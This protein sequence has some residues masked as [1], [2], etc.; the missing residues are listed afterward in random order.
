MLAFIKHHKIWFS[1]IAVILVLS[2]TAIYSLSRSNVDYI[3]PKRGDMVEAIYGLGKVKTDNFYEVKLGI[4][5]TVEQLYVREGDKVKKGDKLVRMENNTIFRAPFDGTVTMIAFRES[6][7]VFPQQTILR[8]E[9]LN[10]KYIEV[11]LE[12][13]G[14]LRVRKGQPVR[15][16][17]ESVRGDV[18]TGKVD[19]IFPRNDEF[20]VHVRVA[21]LGANVLP[22]M[23]ADVSIEVGRKENVLQVPL[24]GI[25][26][27][28]V[29]VLRGDKKVVVPLKIGSVDGNW[30]EVLEGDIRPGDKV[31]V[32]KRPQ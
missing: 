28:R 19:S 32:Q 16:I 11:S 6:Q 9:D 2:G 25:S 23:T 4:I 17:F 22:G 20:L 3:A 1:I 30:A 14:A 21:G 10:N 15:V 8:M 18:L 31:I 5:S 12:Q 7:S 13:Q 27:G 26:S 24:S 29:T